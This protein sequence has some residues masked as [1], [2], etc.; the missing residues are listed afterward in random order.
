MPILP[1]VRLVLL[2]HDSLTRRISAAERLRNEYLDTGNYNSRDK[3]LSFWLDVQDFKRRFHTTSSA[4]AVRPG[5]EKAA[6]SSSGGGI[7]S[8]VGRRLGGGGASATSGAKSTSSN[9][10]QTQFGYTAMERHQQEDDRNGFVI[11][12]TYLAPAS[13]CE[14]NIEHNLRSELVSYMNKVF[15]DAKGLVEKV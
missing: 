5:Q 3:N 2:S 14:L 7:G 11:Y 9:G 6:N 10:N 12:N 4:T 13:P 15:N 8:A 1:R